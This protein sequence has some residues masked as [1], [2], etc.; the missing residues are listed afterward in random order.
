MSLEL[1][2]PSYKTITLAW[3]V[4]CG[5]GAPPGLNVVSAGSSVVSDGEVDPSWSS[6]GTGENLYTRLAREIL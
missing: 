1:A 2:F 6:E 3:N 5:G 4:N